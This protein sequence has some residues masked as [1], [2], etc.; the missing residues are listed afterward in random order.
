MPKARKM[1]SDWQAP[2]LQ[3]LLRT[4]PTQSKATLA[5]WA[6]DYAEKALLPV[7]NKYRPDDSRPREAL[8]AARAWLAGEVKLP[9]VKAAILAC[10]AAA[11]ESEENPAA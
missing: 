4:I 6:L 5:N 3:P 10:H 11:R 9:P 1:L 2:Y 7:W 8:L